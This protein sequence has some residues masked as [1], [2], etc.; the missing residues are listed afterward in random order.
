[1]SNPE[2]N[3]TTGRHALLGLP[4][5][6]D[7]TYG[8]ARGIFRPTRKSLAVEVPEVRSH[9]VTSAY[10]VG[11]AGSLLVQNCNILWCA[12]LNRVHRGGRLDYCAMLHSDVAPEEAWLDTLA[13][14]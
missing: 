7:L 2:K 1:M 10:L 4:F 13:A 5:Y 3:G 14:E 8:A 11:A 6:G 9:E 12:A